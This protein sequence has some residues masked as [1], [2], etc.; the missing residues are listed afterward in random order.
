MENKICLFTPKISTVSFCVCVVHSLFVPVVHFNLKMSRF[1]SKY[2]LHLITIYWIEAVNRKAFCA[3]IQSLKMI[4]C[5]NLGHNMWLFFYPLCP[6]EGEMLLRS[7]LRY[8][9]WHGGVGHGPH[10]PNIRLS[11]AK[12]IAFAGCWLNLAHPSRN[13][14]LWVFMKNGWDLGIMEL[15]PSKAKHLFKDERRKK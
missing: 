11:S 7:S 4:H 3:N 2:Q 6:S 8:S 9:R 13:C 5:F 10:P 14:F 12:I 1:Q 15:Y